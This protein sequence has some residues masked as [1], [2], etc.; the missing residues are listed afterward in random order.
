MWPVWFSCVFNVFTIINESEKKIFLKKIF[1]SSGADQLD[2]SLMVV[3]R[4]YYPRINLFK[5]LLC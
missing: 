5:L 3:V 4:F 2:R 1:F